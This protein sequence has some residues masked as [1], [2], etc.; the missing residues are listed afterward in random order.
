MPGEDALRAQV[1]LGDSMREMALYYATSKVALLGGSFAPL[2]GH[3][4]IEAAA[5]GCPLV[6]GPSTFNFSEAA[7]LSLAAGAS[8]RAGDMGEGVG[9]ATGLLQ[10]PERLAELSAN[11]IRFASQHRGAARRMAQRIMKLI[12]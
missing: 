1:W 10:V 6:M 8:L 2:G 7:A 5:C 12:D 4:L 9:L 3:N 11:A